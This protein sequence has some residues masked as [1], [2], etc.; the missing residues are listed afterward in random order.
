MIILDKKDA[1]ALTSDHS[2]SLRSDIVMS[3]SL[4]DIAHIS[5]ALNSGDYIWIF[6]G[7]HTAKKS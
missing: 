2:A 5:L 1:Y 7:S 3:A 6:L 4:P